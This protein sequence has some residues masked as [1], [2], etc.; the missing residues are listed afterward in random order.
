MIFDEPPLHMLYVY[1]RFGEEQQIYIAAGLEVGEKEIG[2]C[3]GEAEVIDG[4]DGSHRLT[5][6][7]YLVNESSAEECIAVYLPE[8]GYYLYQITADT[9]LPEFLQRS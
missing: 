5:V 4:W 8:E 7:T 2:D 1:A 6:K 9:D 3:I